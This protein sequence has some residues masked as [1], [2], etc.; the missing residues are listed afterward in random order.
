MFRKVFGS[1]RTSYDRLPIETSIKLGIQLSK[2]VA[3]F[4]VLV[5]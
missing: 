3:I 2:D 4:V 1:F 5:K